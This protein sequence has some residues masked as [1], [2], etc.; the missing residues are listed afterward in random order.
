MVT[1]SSYIRPLQGRPAV[2]VSRPP[3]H[4]RRTC[5]EGPKGQSRPCSSAPLTAAS[6]AF[7]RCRAQRLGGA[8]A[9]SGQR[10]R[11]RGGPACSAGRAC[12]FSSGKPSRPAA[13]STIICWP[14]ATWPTSAPA[15]LSAISA[16]SSNS[17]SLADVVQDRRADQHV[18]VEPRVQHAG[19]QR[20]RRHGDR[21]LEQAAQVGVVARARAGRAAEL[22]PER[23]RRQEGVEQRRA[24]PGRRPRARGARGSRRAR[25]GRGRRSAGTRPGRPP[26]RAGSS[27]A[28]PGARRGSAPPGRRPRPGRRARTGRPGS[29]R[30]GRRAP[31]S[32]RCGRAARRPGRGCRCAR[33]GDPCACRRTPRRSRSQ[34]AAR[35]SSI[36]CSTVATFPS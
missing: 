2:A 36:V 23:A 5:V 8:E 16:P 33:S 18:R 34:R 10:R 21:V 24:G 4:G 31:G 11:R 9:P 19:L 12:S 6:S 3:A 35:R 13:R 7:R 22:G 20:E 15:S 30:R 14:S 29:R 26:R 27:A 25:R 17:R 28:R 1:G 32:R